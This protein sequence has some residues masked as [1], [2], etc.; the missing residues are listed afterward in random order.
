MMI[1]LVTI[2]EASCIQWFFDL[3]VSG[4]IIVKVALQ[5]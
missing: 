4:M 5:L 2:F 1:A 3:I